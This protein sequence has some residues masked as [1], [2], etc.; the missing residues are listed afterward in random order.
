MEIPGGNESKIHS[1]NKRGR[2]GN[3]KD[4]RVCEYFGDVLRFIMLWSTYS[5]VFRRIHSLAMVQVLRCSKK[6]QKMT[7]DG[8]G[9]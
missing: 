9:F 7:F 2:W 5:G 4:G 8:K 3:G 6:Y 1:Q